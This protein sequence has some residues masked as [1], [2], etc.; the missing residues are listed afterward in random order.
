MEHKIRVVKQA[1]A[2]GLLLMLLGTL[3]FEVG[4]VIHFVKVTVK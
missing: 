1:L 4:G 3:E 2:S